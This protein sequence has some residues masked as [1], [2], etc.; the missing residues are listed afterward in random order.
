MEKMTFEEKLKHCPP[1]EVWQEYCG[2]LSLSLPEYMNIQKRL[3][4]EQVQLMAGCALGQRFFKGHVPATVEEFRARVPLTR[5]EDYADVLLP[6]RE[7]M[8]PAKPVIWLHT[9][10]EG[11]DFP[12]K[13]APYTESMLETYKTNILAAMLLATSHGRGH[14]HVRPGCRVLYSLAPLPYATG[15]FPDLISSEIHLRF[16]PSVREARKMSFGQQM[17]TGYKLAAKHGMNLFFGMSSVLYG[18][19]RSLNM[20]GGEKA[21]SLRSLLGMSPRM[22]ARLAMAKYRNR[23]DGT[24]L[25]PRD[26]FKLD[27]FVC[28]GTDTVLYKNELEEAWGIR[29]LEIAGGTEPSCMGTETWSKNGLVFFP[30]ACFYEFIPEMELYQ[31][32]ETP[33]YIPKTYLMDELVA[34]QKYE[35]VITVLKGGAFL[36]YRVGDI[37]RCLRLRNPADELDLPQFEYVDR[38]PTVIDIAGFTRI[39][40]REIEQVLSRSRLPVES[41][42]AVKEYDE[43]G[44]SFLDLYVELKSDDEQA[45][46]LDC[47]MLQEL[48]S[49]Y[50]RSYDGDY[51]DLKRLLGMDP[52]RI[53]LL[54]TGTI[55]RYRQQTGRR[56]PPVGTPREIVLDILRLQT[57]QEGGSPA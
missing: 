39:T 42:F 18:A 55:A 2:F 26:L 40:Q 16:M 8:L 30:D 33:G 28:V 14:F 45:A 22:I 31:E 6:Q 47:Q 52:L 41:W 46:V 51:K 35:L 57:A 10:W 37:Y 54:K 15:M 38:I 7:E 48:L 36:R 3:L 29:P 43:D 13:R 9:T 56:V 24:E 53:T 12:S 20:L 1:A 49:V 27:G 34:G 21:P 5:F 32:M 50:F 4:M 25:R 17:R 19:T 11:G 44:H 23:R